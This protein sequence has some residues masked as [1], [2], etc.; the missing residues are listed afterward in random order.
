M[1]TPGLILSPKL[2]LATVKRDRDHRNTVC[3]RSSM[4]RN[5]GVM[6][7]SNTAEKSPHLK[8][9][10]VRFEKILVAVD[11]SVSSSN[12]LKAGAELAQRSGGQ[13][14]VAHVLDPSQMLPSGSVNDIRETLH[15]WTKPYVTREMHFAVEVVEGGLV[16]EMEGIARNHKADILVIGTHSVS[17]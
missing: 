8:N 15:L 9:T 6:N 7:S 16:K 13:L 17:G 3:R 2:S 14:I 5:R 10:R 11:L 12:T 1:T 4:R